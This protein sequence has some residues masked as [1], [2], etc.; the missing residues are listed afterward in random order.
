MVGDTLN[1]INFFDSKKRSSKSGVDTSNYKKYG[2]IAAVVLLLLI[3]IMTNVILNR[4]IAALN[5]EVNDLNVQ[6]DTL[7]TEFENQNPVSDTT[8]PA[9]GKT[10]KEQTILEIEALDSLNN[11]DSEIIIQ[12]QNSI[13]ANL[14]LSTLTLTGPDLVIK[15][16]A[17][18]SNSVA[19]F[20][21]N[22]NQREVIHD[23]FVPT[24]DNKIGSY[25]FTI[26]AKIRS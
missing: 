24:I 15:G 8:D 11:I 6:R 23:A 7:M 18:D 9:S 3:L 14:F 13:P 21:Y 4:Q 5:A 22:L 1:E 16:Y 10:V 26:N 25:E 20:Q 17:K 12:I 19:Q 2:I